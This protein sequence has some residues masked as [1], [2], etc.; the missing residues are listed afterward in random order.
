MQT[1]FQSLSIEERIE[2]FVKCQEMLIKYHSS[3]GFVIRENTLE[4]AVASC[5]G[6]IHKY[7]GFVYSDDNVCVLW[8]HIKVSDS[9]DVQRILKENA[10]QPPHP[11]YNGVSIDF[12]VFRHIKDC[13][14]FVKKNQTPQMEYVLFIREGRPKLY[15]ISDILKGI[16]A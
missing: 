7:N 5:Q 16:G 10:Y 11:Q 9:S 2:F 8:N 6:N 15:P 12:A 1:L 14:D 13:L 4:K 3:S